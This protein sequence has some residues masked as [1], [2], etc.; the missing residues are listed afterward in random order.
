MDFP[1]N[2]SIYATLNIVTNREGGILLIGKIG[3]IFLKVLAFCLGIWLLS[4]LIITIFTD[5]LNDYDIF[6]TE[7][8][9]AIVTEKFSEKSLTGTPNYYVTV[10]LNEDGSSNLIQNKVLSWQFKRLEVG[11]AI[12]GH[13]IHGE[14]FFTTLDIVIDSVVVIFILLLFL[15]L[16]LLL[17][18]WPIFIFIEKREKQNKP[19]LFLKEKKKIKREDKN[20]EKKHILQHFFPNF[21]IWNMFFPT[22]LVIAILFT[23]GFVIN[24]IQKF[25]PIGKT[26]TEALVIDSGAEREIFYYFPAKYA[27]PYYS[28]DLLFTDENNDRE[29]R[30]VKEVTSSVYDKRYIGDKIKISYV[31]QNPYNVFVPD[32]SL[33]NILETF[34]YNKFIWK[35]FVLLS[36]LAFFMIKFYLDKK[37]RNSRRR[38]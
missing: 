14:H 1:A 5:F 25:S 24:G 13:Y 27:D 22:L 11:D 23:S 38:G 17:L 10:D 3:G 16:L 26:T 15:F 21:S 7:D 28:L 33:L 20:K 29:Y 2:Y 36:I 6:H 18:S 35:I 30:V 4:Y 31:T 32:F 37:K 9:P 34:R 19:P 12:K 8:N